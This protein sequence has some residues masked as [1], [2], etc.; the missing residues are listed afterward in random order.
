[1]VWRDL[2]VRY[3]QTILGVGWAVVQ[4]LLNTVVFTLIFGRLVHV[5][6]DGVP[7]PVF[8]L[9]AVVPWTYVSTAFAASGQSLLNSS[10]LIT[11]VYFPRL[12][13]PWAP[14]CSAGVDFAIGVVLLGGA[15]LMYG[16]VPSAIALAVVPGSVVAFVLTAAGVGCWTSAL[17][18]QYR[19][20]KHLIPF[21]STV[22]MY[23]S[24]VVY[25]MSRIPERYRVWYALNPLAG[26]LAAFRNS[27]VGRPI[28]W[29]MWAESVG[30]AV[31]VF[32]TGTFYFRR[33]ER[34]FA[35]VV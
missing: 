34:V 5:P 27:L 10:N 14:V 32:V 15:L 4:P 25:P 29:S 3:T 9:A 23:L 24:P 13:I 2:K 16:Q 22:W 17:S 11:K 6:T 1:L 28:D 19:D 18:I 35:D 12:V 8:A 33:T 31:L 30:I 26:T 7:Y 20:V 21:A